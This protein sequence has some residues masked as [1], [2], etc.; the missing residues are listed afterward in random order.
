LLTRR[1]LL[2][3]AAGFTAVAAAMPYIDAR[4][5]WMTSTAFAATSDNPKRASDAYKAMQAQ[6]PPP[7]Y[8]YR[9]ST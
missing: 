3:R 8:F 2:I 9:A 4:T 5:G 6:V 7:P 1:S